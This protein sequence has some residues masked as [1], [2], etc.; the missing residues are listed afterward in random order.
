MRIKKVLYILLLVL[1]LS[2]YALLHGSSVQAETMYSI[3]ET[4]LTALEK[5]LETLKV[6]SQK[7]QEVLTEQAKLLTE[8]KAEIKKQDEELKSLQMELTN[9]KAANE[10]TLK[11]LK[12]AN[13]YL[14][15]LEKEEKHKM[16]VKT[17]QRNLWIF[18]AGVSGIVAISK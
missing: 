11:S 1:P 15:K 5:N 17:R 2:F 12:K 9:S 16:R 7:R 10:A 6:N 18:I 13:E 4:E 14:D 8:Q 3:S